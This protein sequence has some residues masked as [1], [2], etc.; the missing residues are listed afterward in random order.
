LIDDAKKV[1]VVLLLGHPVFNCPQV[2]AQM[3]FARGLNAREGARLGHRE[4]RSQTPTRRRT[5]AR[6]VFFRISREAQPVGS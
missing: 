5:R 2:V 6:K 1:L 4:S 3:Q